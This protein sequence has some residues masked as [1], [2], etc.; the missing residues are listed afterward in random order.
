MFVLFFIQI[1]VVR[2][3]LPAVGSSPAMRKFLTKFGEPLERGFTVEIPLTPTEKSLIVLFH[4][5]KI[6]I[7]CLFSAIAKGMVW[8]SHF[9]RVLICGWPQNIDLFL[10]NDL[11]FWLTSRFSNVRFQAEL[12]VRTVAGVSLES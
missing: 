5:F 1:E 2:V 6:S 10:Q 7:I 9:E 12:L 11:Q 3:V 4:F 8:C